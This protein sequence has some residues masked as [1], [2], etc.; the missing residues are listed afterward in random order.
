MSI[1]NKKIFLLV[2]SLL[3]TMTFAEVCP[4]PHNAND[5]GWSIIGGTE[6]NLVGG[7]E[8]NSGV[9]FTFKRAI[10]NPNNSTVFC[11]FDGSD[12]TEV[13]IKKIVTNFNTTNSQWAKDQYG[14]YECNGPAVERCE[15]RIKN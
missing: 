7:T 5:M 15:I 1:M 6:T 12:N 4:N 8:L 10:Y 3:A 11:L 9:T 14:G 2:G 13:R